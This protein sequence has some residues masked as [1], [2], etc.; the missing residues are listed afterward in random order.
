MRT[1]AAILTLLILALAVACGETLAPGPV[2]TADAGGPALSTASTTVTLYGEELPT[3]EDEIIYIIDIS[4]SM[5][6]G[7][8]TYTDLNGNPTSGSK[9]DRAKVEVIRSIQ[10]MPETLRFN[11]VA[12]NCQSQFW[13]P[14]LRPSTPNYKAAAAEWVNGLQSSG[15]AATGPAVRDA[16]MGPGSSTIALISNTPPG[17]GADPAV[18]RDEEPIGRG[19]RG[20]DGH[21]Q[22]I[23]D[24]NT[25]GARI[26]TI[27]LQTHGRFVTFLSSIASRTGG[28]YVAVP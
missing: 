8:Q 10:G 7:T 5:G 18:V 14:E 26:H 25:G 3:E 13:E 24:T 1:H 17:C 19:W 2:E 9:L 16:L 6:W 22:M 4:G 27:G 21:L 12:Y 20:F 15:G 28:T 11:V 23:T